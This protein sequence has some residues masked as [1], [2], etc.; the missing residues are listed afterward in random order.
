MI[1]LLV[2]DFNAN[3]THQLKK[4]AESF[5]DKKSIQYQTIHVP[6][7]VELPI[8]AQQLIRKN[9]KIKAVI[10]LGCVIKGATD[11]YDMVIRSCTDGLN[12]VS[13]DEG[14]PVIQG[15][16]ASPNFDLAWQRRDAGAQY[17]ETAV[18]MIEILKS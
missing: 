18:K 12:R 13:L 15:V 8:A 7:A 10:A 3:I 14:I 2:A 6:G 4:S 16:L 1:L 5:L 17:A 11:H 9:K